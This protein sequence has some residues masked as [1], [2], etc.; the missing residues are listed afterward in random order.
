M[1]KKLA[2][3]SILAGTS[4]ATI[5][6]INSVHT[7]L[8]TIKDLLSSS[9]NFFYDWRFGKIRYQKKGNG[10]PLLFVHDLTIGSSNYEYH[11]LINNLT[12]KHEIYSIDLLGYGMSDKPA[13]TYTNNLYEQLIADFIKNVIGRKTSVVVT[14]ESVPFVIMAC[15]NYPDIFN[16]LVCIN[17]QSLYLQ[18]QIPSKQTSLLKLLIETPV[19]GT[20]I[21]HLFSNK[22]SIERA[23]LKTY[24]YNHEEIK[25]KYIYNYLEA[26][27]LGGYNSKYGFASYAGKYMYMNILHELKEIN[28]S[29]LMIGGEKEK[30]IKTTIENYK[31]YNASIE[32]AYISDTKHLPHMEAPDEILKQLG[33]FL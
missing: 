5:H 22:T 18:N 9:E 30:D 29:I 26:A 4:V 8:C 1:H 13:M 2:T 31:Y 19:I 28:N 33:M 11:R 7:S 17:P 3:I 20:F 25:E 23:F 24:F 6:G 21:Y 10:N 15:H 27:H 16:K 32:D 14:G 12:E